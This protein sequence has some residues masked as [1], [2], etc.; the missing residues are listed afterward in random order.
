MVWRTNCWRSS[1]T[2]GRGGLVR[3]AGRQAAFLGLGT[4]TV[5]E[6]PQFPRSLINPGEEWCGVRS[7]FLNVSSIFKNSCFIAQLR[8]NIFYNI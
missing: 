3:A 8:R 5:T 4:K 2:V 6:R 1:N 7:S